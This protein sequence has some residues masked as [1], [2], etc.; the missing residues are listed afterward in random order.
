MLQ[1]NKRSAGSHALSRAMLFVAAICLSFSTTTFSRPDDEAVAGQTYYCDP[2][3]GSMSNSG[4]AA[5]PWS[6]LEEVF[7]A[8]KTFQAG[9]I[10]YLLSGFHG[11]PTVQGHNSDYV[12]IMPQSGHTPEVERLIVSDASYWTISGLTVS[13]EFGTS[14]KATLVSVADNCSDITI[15]DNL[16]YAAADISGWDAATWLAT[17]GNGIVSGAPNSLI[18]GN[19]IR[20][21]YHAVEIHK[22]GINSVVSENTIENFGGDGIRGLGDYCKYEYNLIKNAF[23]IN[24]NHDDFFQSWSTDENGTVGAGVVVGV[25]VRG[26]TLLSYTDPD[27]PLK[28]TP[29][30]ISNFDGFSEDWIIENNLVVSD[31]WHGIAFYGANNCKIINNTVVKNKGNN[32]NTPWIAVFDHKDGRPSTN[33]L[34]RNN[35]TSDI[36][37]TV[38]TAEDHNL[39]VTNYEAQFV[40]AAGYDF[41]LKPLST[42]IDAGTSEGAPLLDLEKVPRSEPID[43][44]CY[45]YVPS[46][47]DN[48]K[49]TTP[50]DLSAD[51]IS[52]DRVTLSWSPS[53][54]ET[55]LAGYRV[56]RDG[57]NPVVA[58]DTTVTVKGLTGNTIYQFTVVAIDA[59]GNASDPGEALEVTT[60]APP[61]GEQSSST[62]QT[63]DLPLQTG[64][65]MA[66]FDVVPVED[67]MDGV[68]GILSGTASAYGSLACLMRFNPGGFIDARNGGAYTSTNPVPYT[69]GASYHFRVR[70]DVPTHTYS[71]YVTPEGQPEQ[72]MA[73]D[74]AFRSEQAAVT[75]L[76]GWAIIAGVGS[77]FVANMEVATLDT[78]APSIPE[79]LEVASVTPA[80]VD[81]RWRASSDN[82]GVQEY[83][84]YTNGANPVSVA[85]TTVTIDRLA[86]NTNYLFTVAA[87]DSAGNMSAESDPV[88]VETLRFDENDMVAYWPFEEVQCTPLWKKI[89]IEKCITPDHTGH[90]YDGLVIGADPIDGSMGNALAFRGWGSSVYVENITTAITDGLTLATW[91]KPDQWRGGIKKSGIILH[92]SGGNYLSPQQEHWS[93]GVAKKGRRAELVFNLN[94]GS[95]LTVLK[96]TLDKTDGW[97]HVAATYD[98]QTMRLFVSGK[99]VAARE[100]EGVLQ[101]G[102]AAVLIGS[103]GRLIDGFAGAIDEVYVMH[104][105]L[106][107]AGIMELMQRSPVATGRLVVQTSAKSEGTSLPDVSAWEASDEVRVYPNPL[108]GNGALTVELSPSS[109]VMVYDMSGRMLLQKKVATHQLLLSKE[110]FGKAGVYELVII[111]PDKTLKTNRVVIQ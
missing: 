92:K 27:Q 30:G 64:T 14:G 24:D 67:N 78:E 89:P 16:V 95:K 100:T 32:P 23:K 35:L 41:H 102:D 60:L 17:A 29:Q 55:A 50:Q 99:E 1:S 53:V 15:Q 39:I 90:G 101:A 52:F 74:F 48:I 4:D 86:R 5:N 77:H 22:S 11:L 71:V 106:D 43:I 65:F 51:N 13:T 38:G 6:T 68:V 59:N 105:P 91:I 21:T 46:G 28:A 72:L 108:S 47:S 40:D 7:A 93:V 34:M 45:E 61:P 57:Q 9:D 3:N 18:T 103:G 73:E 82:V 81:L 80:S 26:N 94:T 87:V 88:A 66:T 75:Q 37:S 36:E 96:A 69:G 25:E 110:Q 104:Q 98:G 107:E 62:W 42:A 19:T 12:T 10:I 63:F 83:R 31:I 44:G 54:D 8:G 49:P 2:V 56:Y 20:N 33:N 97:M 58:T 84:V 76:D 111:A 70:I 85:D 79:A 109:E